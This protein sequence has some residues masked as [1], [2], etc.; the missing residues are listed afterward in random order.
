VDK[1][2]TFEANF[3]RFMEANYPKIGDQIAKDKELKP[4]TE[5]KLKTAIAEFKKDMA[6]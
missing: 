6:L 2:T 4:E 5:E 1:V 3:H